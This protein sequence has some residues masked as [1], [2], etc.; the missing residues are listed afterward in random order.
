M[1]LQIYSNERNWMELQSVFGGFSPTVEN[2]ID[3]M[4]RTT[5]VHQTD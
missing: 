1:R 3:E 2:S 5:L 4:Q